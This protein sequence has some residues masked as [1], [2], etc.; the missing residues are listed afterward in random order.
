MSARSRTKTKSLRPVGFHVLLALADGERHGY[1]IKQEVERLTEGAIRMGP[2]TLYET[3]QKLEDD[4]LIRESRK[5]AGETDHAQRRYY[6]LTDRGRRLL[7]TE[8]KRLA[9]IVD[10]ARA[11]VREETA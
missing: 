10:Y 9:R 8:I 3:L 11:K 7:E 4:E 6:R 2:G 5:P 1:A